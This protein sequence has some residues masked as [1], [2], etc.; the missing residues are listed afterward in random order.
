MS[1]KAYLWNN[2]SPINNMDPSGLFAMQGITIPVF[3]ELCG[4]QA[5]V[6]ALGGPYTMLDAIPGLGNILWTIGGPDFVIP[7]GLK[8]IAVVTARHHCNERAAGFQAPPGKSWG[9]E[10]TAGNANGLN[11]LAAWSNIGPGST[12]FNYQATLGQGLRAESNYGLGVYGAGGGIPEPLVL[13]AI[14]GVGYADGLNT[15]QVL[16]DS[17]WADEGYQYADQYCY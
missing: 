7:P 5:C 8:T 9:Q 13:A 10:Y 1:Q 12:T 2:N 17:I 14:V 15:S 4:D 11:P 6:T 3:P 16:Q